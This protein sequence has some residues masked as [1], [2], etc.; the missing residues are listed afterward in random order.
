VPWAAASGQ[1]LAI[2]T[3]AAG[4]NMSESRVVVVVSLFWEICSV[5]GRM[6]SLRSLV[7]GVSLYNPR[8]VG[9]KEEV[10]TYLDDVVLLLRKLP[11]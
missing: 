4:L 6:E 3:G 7:L 10:V 5:M 11:S 8:L 9:S 2:G 1:G